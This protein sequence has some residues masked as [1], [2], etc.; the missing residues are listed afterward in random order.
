MKKILGEIVTILFAY[1]IIF[2]YDYY[3]GDNKKWSWLISAIIVIVVYVIMKL[4]LRGK[5]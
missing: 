2:V 5:K 3:N 4:C 1:I